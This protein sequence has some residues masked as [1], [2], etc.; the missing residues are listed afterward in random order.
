[1]AQ[2]LDGMRKGVVSYIMQQRGHHK[3][4]HAADLD[5]IQPTIRLALQERTQCAQGQIVAAQ[6]V[7]V[8]RMGR[9]W[10]DAVHKPELLYL[11]EAQKLGSIDQL[12]F[13]WAKRNQI[14]QAIA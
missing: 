10:P 4:L 5:A 2:L 7:L 6:A 9:T 8:A 3:R 14:I 1:M 13:A 12:F 11:L